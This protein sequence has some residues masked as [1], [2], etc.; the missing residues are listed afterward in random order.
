MEMV[1]VQSMDYAFNE[2]ADIKEDER[3]LDVQI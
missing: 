2:Y 1:T 3:D